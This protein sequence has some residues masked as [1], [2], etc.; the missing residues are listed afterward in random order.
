MKKK[1]QFQISF[2]MIFSIIIIV[3]TIAVSG[4]VITNFLKISKCSDI[5]LFYNDLQKDVDKAWASEITNNLFEGKLPGGIESVCFGNVSSSLGDKSEE[6]EFLRRYYRQDKNIFLYP[7]QRACD[8]NLAYHKL[9]HIQL[10]EFFCV[11]A[12]SGKVS[13]RISKSNQESLVRI[14]PNK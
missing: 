9:N 4:Y 12:D 8:S 2:G 13:F 3:A 14:S 6:A 7:T 11:S 5:G 10:S 1:G